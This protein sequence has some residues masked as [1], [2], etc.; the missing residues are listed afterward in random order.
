MTGP[1]LVTGGSGYL[2]EELVR[3]APGPVVGVSRSAELGLD[4]RDG[5]AVHALFAGLR[6]R[7][8]IHTAYVQDG[9][10]AWETNVAGS[11]NVAAAAA[12]VG[13]RM[14]HLSTDVVFDGTKGAPYDERD[15]PRPL[16]GYGRSK[17]EAEERVSAAHPG[18]L[19]VRTS[20]LVGR[21]RP[22]RQERAIL[23]AA[24]GES[25]TAFFTDELRSPLLVGDLAAALVELSW[26]DESGPLHVGGPEPLS[27]HE[28]A[29]IVAAAHGLD[30]GRIR[31]GSLAAS[32]LERPAACVLD[33]SRARALLAAAPSS[34][35]TLRARQTS[36]N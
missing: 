35:R 18:A 12:G 21:E 9:P 23:A 27:R 24:S 11:E 10:E 1:L 28:L 6:P 15:P 14:V 4:V 7:A 13:A 31:A 33:S 20:L 16:T 3:L 25:G 34:V 5:T 2:G 29:R 17:A 8:V 32:G 36:Q 30:P 19:I 26:R 22:G